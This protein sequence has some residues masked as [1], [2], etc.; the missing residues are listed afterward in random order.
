M[1]ILS[2][3]M[4]VLSLGFAFSGCQGG[5]EAKEELI[6]I[7]LA[8]TPVIY[9]G[10][11]AVADQEGF[12]RQSGLDVSIRSDYPAGL[13]SMQALE[14]GE[15]QMATGAAF[16]FSGMMEDDP[17]LRVLASVGSTSDHEIVARKD[18]G[19]LRPSDLQGKR[20]GVVLDTVSEY[21]LSMFLQMNNID[22]ATL[23]LVD[24]SPPEMPEALARGEVDAISVWGKFSYLAIKRLGENSVSWPSQYSL[25]YHWVLA[26]KEDLLANSPEVAKRFLLA[27]KQAE[28]FVLSNEEAA[29]AIITQKWGLE[30]DFVTQ[31]WSKNKLRVALD[32]PLIISLENAIRWRM[33]N[34]G[35]TEEMPNILSKIHQAPL[36]E[37]DPKAVT[38]YR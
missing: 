17:S 4:L 30:Q 16:V 38:L 11:I 1:G 18:R 12:F 35:K 7:S 25:D 14:R 27:L 33:R 24:I 8:T 26:A 32:Q 6:K 37:I 20:I 2:F 36:E 21:A 31:V 34:K 29:R 3:S 22:P 5:Q 28:R 10:L 23:T 19:I 9:T 15:V 13:Q